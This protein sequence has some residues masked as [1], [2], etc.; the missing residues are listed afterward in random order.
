[1]S[2]SITSTAQALSSVARAVVS[3]FLKESPSA[4]L[5]DCNGLHSHN[6][7]GDDYC[8]QPLAGTRTANE[9]SFQSLMSE[10]WEASSFSRAS[11]HR[12]WWWIGY[13]NMDSDWEDCTDMLVGWIV[14]GAFVW[15]A[16]RLLL[17]ELEEEEKKLEQQNPKKKQQPTRF[18]PTPTSIAARSPGVRSLR[19]D[20]AD[21]SAASTPRSTPLV[22]PDVPEEEVEEEEAA[23]LDSAMDEWSRGLTMVLDPVERNAL[24][25]DSACDV[26]NDDFCVVRVFCGALWFRFHLVHQF[27][28]SVSE[29]FAELRPLLKTV[30]V[31]S[32]FTSD[33]NDKLPMN[34]CLKLVQA[35]LEPRYG[36]TV[37][38]L[39]EVL[40]LLT[41]SGCSDLPH[42]VLDQLVEEILRREMKVAPVPLAPSPPLTTRRPRSLPEAARHVRHVLVWLNVLRV[43]R[44]SVIFIPEPT[45]KVQN[46]SLAGRRERRSP[47]L[48][49]SPFARRGSSESSLHLASALDITAR[50]LLSLCLSA[51]HV[52][53]A[54]R[55]LLYS[56]VADARIREM[57]I[58][59]AVES[60]LDDLDR[61]VLCWSASNSTG[62]IEATVAR[63]CRL[64]ATSALQY[65][66]AAEEMVSSSPSASL[67]PTAR[68]LHRLGRRLVR[69]SSSD[70][71]FLGLECLERAQS[72]A[73]LALGDGLDDVRARFS[74]LALAHRSVGDLRRAAACERVARA[75]PVPDSRLGNGDDDVAGV[76]DPWPLLR[77]LIGLGA[78]FLSGCAGCQLSGSTGVTVDDPVVEELVEGLRHGVDRVGGACELLARCLGELDFGLSGAAPAPSESVRCA[79]LL[80]AAAA[81]CQAAAS[82][83]RRRLAPSE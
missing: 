81:A 25:Q 62:A 60:W 43:E 63:S 5:D 17:L 8:T 23:L 44:G 58:A 47:P 56:A 50:Y 61:L 22:E 37:Q 19:A 45:A 6:C 16:V 78:A 39:F 41:K 15:I 11:S 31:P 32:S 24:M 30:D 48:W 68:A 64:L 35:S 7:N 27:R 54:S 3:H 26:Q 71:L 18:A 12:G 34:L 21:S 52:G 74:G 38:T 66:D 75:A 77:A 49:S 67:L 46:G 65:H 80:W 10:G 53:S 69:E 42:L 28:R 59:R 2:A 83:H 36:S 73:V 76:C 1:M 79:A 51:R 29:V 33:G 72:L 57:G 40:A 82:S 4:A 20:S 70:P 9:T 55:L 13:S 14:V